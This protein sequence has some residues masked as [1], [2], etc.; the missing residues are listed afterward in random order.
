MF[1]DESAT[2]SNLEFPYAALKQH[3][4]L[5]GEVL[6]VVFEVTASPG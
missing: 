3:E 1:Y 2:H 4:V 5:R 6:I